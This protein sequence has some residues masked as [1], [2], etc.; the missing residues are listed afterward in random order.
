MMK[1]NHFVLTAG[2]L[3]AASAYA[4]GTAYAA[5]EEQHENAK[6]ASHEQESKGKHDGEALVPGVARPVTLSNQGNK[7]VEGIEIRFSGNNPREF[8]QSNNCGE[9]LKGKSSCVIS[10]IFAPRTPGAKSATME[11]HTTG[12]SK[13]VYLTG[14]GV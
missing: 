10:V 4:V 11:I 3:L 8:T 5:E 13:Y 7:T 12:G 1:P 9:E 2:I 14:A 6:A